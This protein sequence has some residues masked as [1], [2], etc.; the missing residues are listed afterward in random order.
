MSLSDS[1]KTYSIKLHAQENLNWELRDR[2]GIKNIVYAAKGKTESQNLII[3]HKELPKKLNEEI[4]ALLSIKISDKNKTL[5]EQAIKFLRKNEIDTLGDLIS[6]NLEDI[7]K[8]SNFDVD[9][10]SD[11]IK[12]VDDYK[13]EFGLDLSNINFN[14]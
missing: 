5:S 11:L 7:R 4:V 14:I 13:L 2:K 10:Q 9:I 6:Y 1:S 8:L 12:L 3:L